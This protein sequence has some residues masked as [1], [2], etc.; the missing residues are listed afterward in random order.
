[1]AKRI[2]NCTRI[3]LLERWRAIEDEE[4]AAAVEDEGGGGNDARGDSSTPLRLHQLKEQ[5]FVDTFNFLIRLP[6]ENHIWCD[7]W[8]LMSPLLETF[9]NYYKDEREDSP[10][11]L[12][13]RRISE[14]MRTCI[15]CVSQHHQTQEMYSMEYESSSVGPLLDVV[16]SLD[17]DRVTRCLKDING[18]MAKKEYLPVNGS[19][20]VVSV[21]YEVLMHP[22][23]LDDQSLFTEF[24][25]FIEAVDNIHE[26]ALDGNQQFP[27]VYAL[28]FFKRRV[29]AVAHRLA[30]AVGN[31]RRA[32]DLEP[33]QPLLQKFIGFLETEV[34]P[35]DQESSKTK[36][37]LDR[38]TVWLGIKSLLGCMDPPAIEEGILECYPIFLDIVLN[39]IS[40]D[41]PVFSNAVSCLKTLFEKLGCKLWLLPGLSPSAMRSTLVGQS[42]HTRSEKIHKDIFDLFQPFL[43]SLEAL[44]DGELEKQRRNFL[45]FLLHQVPVSSNFS[46]LTKQKA[47]QIALLIVMR[48][49]KMNPPSPPFECSHMWGP[50]LVSSLK[51]FSL[52]SSLRQPALDL[53]QIILVSD[54]AALVMSTL[55]SHELP[56]AD[57]IAIGLNFAGDDGPAFMPHNEEKDESSWSDFNLQTGVICQE[58]RGWMCIPMLWTDVL[59]ETDIMVLPPSF[60]KAVFWARSR[61][62]FIEPGVGADISMPIKTWLLS[63]AKEISSSFG[64]RIPTGSDDGGGSN[65]SKNS[66]EVLTMHLPLIKTFN[67]LTAHFLV[68]IGQQQLQKQWLWEPKMSESIILL[69]ADPNDNVRQIGKLILEEVSHTQG[70]SNGLKFLC[71]YKASLS[72][73][74]S[75]LKHGL[76]LVE[77][78][79]AMVKFQ[80]LQ[81][82][83]F[84]LRK[85]LKEG[86]LPTSEI[87]G[88]SSMD[89]RAGKYSSQGG[90]L[91]QPSLES[92]V[93]NACSPVSD[94][95]LHLQEKFSYCLSEAIW[96]SLQKV[97]VDG[98]T[99]IDCSS[100]QMTC[101]RVLELIPVVVENLCPA[102]VVSGDF[103]KIAKSMLD[104]RWMQDLMDWG[105]SSLN[106]VLV[107]WR[108]TVLSLLAILK[109]SFGYISVSTV[110]TIEESIACE[111]IPLDEIKEQLSRLTVSLCE[112]VSSAVL[113]SDSNAKMLLPQDPSSATKYSLSDV[114][115]SR[116]VDSDGQSLDVIIKSKEK[117]PSEIVLLSDDDETEKH[118][119]SEIPSTKPPSAV[120]LSAAES[121]GLIFDAKKAA[122]VSENRHPQKH[123]AKKKLSGSSSSKDIHDSVSQKDAVRLASQKP[124]YVN[125]VKPLDVPLKSKSVGTNTSQITSSGSI[126]QDIALK[127]P[128]E[129]IVAERKKKSEVSEGSDELLKALV[130]DAKDDTLES[131]LNSA[132]PPPLFIPKAPAVIPK[133]QVIQLKSHVRNRWG[134]HQNTVTRRFKPP[135][136]DDW[137]RPILE[138]D[139]FA[140]MGQSSQHGDNN[141]SKLKEV[142][143]CFES[144]E[145]YVDIFLPLV[146][147]EFKAQLH[148]SYLEMSSWEDV[149]CGCL[150]VLSIDRVDDFHHVRFVHEESDFASNKSFSENDLVL[151]TKEPVHNPSHE[152]HM[153]GKVERRERD[154]K[155]KSSILTIRFYL[156]SSTSRLN[157]ARKL[158]IE[159][160][161]W[162]GSR[163]MSITPQ[164]REFQAV[165]SIKDIPILPIILNPVESSHVSCEAKTADSGQLS[166]PLQQILESSFNG[167]QLQAIRVAIGSLNSMKD[168][169]MSLIQGPPGT[170]KTRTIVAIVSGLL[171]SLQR[172]SSRLNDMRQSSTSCVKSRIRI[173]ECTA[174]ARAWQ[175]AA[176][177]KQLEKDVETNNAKAMEPSTRGRV[178]ICAQSNAAV[179]ELVSRITSEGLYGSD[180][181]AYQPYLVR[182]GNAK[183]VHSNSLP[184]F[185]DTLVDLRLAEERNLSGPGGDIPLD[186]SAALRANL[187]KLVDRIRFYE[188]RRANLGDGNTNH[189][190]SM[191]DD[192]QQSD[193]RKELSDTELEKMLKELYEQ[194]KQMYRDLS[195][196]QSRE[197]KANDETRAL[198]HKLRK[199]VLREAEIVVTTLSGSGGDLYEVCSENMSNHKFGNPSEHNLFDAVIID[200]AAQALEPA[201]LIPLQ[202]LKSRGTKCIMVGDPKQ[203]PATVISNIASKFQYECSMFERLQRAGHPVI[204]LTKQYRMHPEISRFPSQFF[205]DGKLL[206]GCQKSAPFHDTKCLG[207]YVFYDITDGLELR[208]DNSGSMSLCNEREADAAVE[209]LRF[210]KR[211]YPSEFFGGRIGVITPYKRQLSILRV[212][213]S[214]AFGSSAVADMEFNTVDGFQGREVDI[215][216]LSTVRAANPFPPTTG[217]SSSSIGF[218]ADV[219]R[220]NVALTR[221]KLSLWILGNARTLQTNRSW[222][223]LIEDA[224]ARNL[225][226]PVKMPYRFMPENDLWSSEL[227]NCSGE[228]SETTHNK[229]VKYTSRSGQDKYGSSSREY[230]LSNHRKVKVKQSQSSQ[231]NVD[232]VAADD[233]GTA[234]NA[235]PPLSEKR[236][237]T[238][239]TKKRL[240][241]G[242]Q[243]HVDSTSGG[244]KPIRY[245]KLAGN[246]AHT[247][248]ATGDIHKHL[249]KPVSQKAAKST[250][251]SKSG[252]NLSG[253]KH[254]HEN[255]SE[256]AAKSTEHSRSKKM[257]AASVSSSQSRKQETTAKDDAKD[258]S[259]V[260]KNNDLISKRKQQRE[261]VDAL[262]SSALIP[263]KKRE[264]NAKA[265][266]LKR[267]L[268]ETSNASQ[269]IQPPKRVK[270]PLATSKDTSRH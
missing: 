89:S 92:L 187:E 197:K 27:G 99:Y 129:S 145:Q 94:A 266:P 230:E 130:H 251:P 122:S 223:T 120:D 166:P 199:S 57:S 126:S 153:I 229:R 46:V 51:D 12:L 164:L 28:F 220:M 134:H 31:L 76:K 90:F 161:K 64:W 176:L 190:H 20:E 236:A 165:S 219:R 183:T 147:E 78:G 182:V 203:L 41:S 244:K 269:E 30:G 225:V 131:A 215:L 193:D 96:P 202:L 45:Y 77:L 62:S 4:E 23:L 123:P 270:V 18:R 16:R 256:N 109:E 5:W 119:T 65:V 115:P 247:G 38:A 235:V 121:D 15:R 125:S 227:Q 195:S 133:R 186:T 154:H 25:T 128:S 170:G 100:C 7:S 70:L 255:V 66:M 261:A 177:A 19:A 207:P 224:K 214:A 97:L 21:M 113:N 264:A 245:E 13:W 43:Q 144:P 233:P 117:D 91:H 140:L 44:Q 148:S 29:R 136:L 104:L 63:S 135:R 259:L 180:G 213:F 257:L 73:A 72:A 2:A 69:L 169:E 260:G 42:F 146:L 6:K 192:T 56:S 249:E 17:K 173:R 83:L 71:S 82:F 124:K 139:Y 151:L 200:E 11:R 196:A 37:Q 24:E 149:Y 142:P 75:G 127:K 237:S 179:D 74:L 52:H 3:D 102:T 163:I 175:N 250:D 39:Q 184:C 221:A 47:R 158:L 178:L 206:D 54:C 87:P 58:Y 10:L 143:Q 59:V 26:L 205:Y 157:K 49:Y 34:I 86:N 116:V 106:V 80:T 194:K 118:M 212:R 95:D 191:N 174:I 98:K 60:S 248:K 267:S 79:P 232:S 204:M 22:I 85:L 188:D 114:Q 243:H 239:K 150:S 8:E 263:S 185:I 240:H 218:V 111:K 50:S 211:R 61:L 246:S 107:Y 168:F 167:S 216:I 9:Y 160:S 137:Y 241:G 93:M 68:Q 189:G 33:L 53:I 32:T 156:Q 1:M 222:A 231:K 132:K 253:S 201:T 228:V 110:G 234:N 171:A 262:L 209:L 103:K 217:V 172:K 226:I 40:S 181:K 138:M 88:K 67:R 101:V 254:S 210:F 108:R 155:R 265:V 141:V 55:C 162:H 268:S 105:K 36:L 238:G 242:E 35:S 252:K 14:E 112:E 84:L 159:R 48:G 81:H 198:R 152:I 208:G 258:P